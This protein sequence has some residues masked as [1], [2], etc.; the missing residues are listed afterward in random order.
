MEAILS[1]ASSHIWFDRSESKDKDLVKK[2]WVAW[3]SLL[4]SLVFFVFLW[5]L[6]TLHK[7]VFFFNRLCQILTLC[8]TGCWWD[9]NWVW[10]NLFANPFL[11]WFLKKPLESIKK[12]KYISGSESSKLGSC[13]LIFLTRVLIIV[14]WIFKG[15]KLSYLAPC[16]FLCVKPSTFLY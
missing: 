6:S 8:S 9:L 5:H 1:K 11:S 2:R 12:A 7:Q 10:K 13:G 16:D 14:D 15:Q 4:L 3:I